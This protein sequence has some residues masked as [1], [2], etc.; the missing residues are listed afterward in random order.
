MHCGA[1]QATSPYAIVASAALR[2]RSRCP[3]DLVVQQPSPGTHSMGRSCNIEPIHTRTRTH[4]RSPQRD[5]SLA[6]GR[7]LQ[8]F[9][10]PPSASKNRRLR[11]PISSTP[12]GDGSSMAVS[13]PAELEPAPA[14]APAPALRSSGVDTPDAR[15]LASVPL[16]VLGGSDAAAAGRRESSS[17]RRHLLLRVNDSFRPCQS[18]CITSEKWSLGVHGRSFTLLHC[19]HPAPM[20]MSPTMS[21]EHGLNDEERSM[22]RSGRHGGLEA[23]RGM[24]Q[25]G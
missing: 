5:H 4:A 23:V 16:P 25:P 24:V 1:S 19:S 6:A 15:L 3:L 18:S 8:M 21:M 20:S 14:P 11:G 2:H 7:S 22:M 12:S 17:P 9:G 13:E 10:R